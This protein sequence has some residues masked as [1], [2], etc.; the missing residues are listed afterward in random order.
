MRNRFRLAL[1]AGCAVLTLAVFGFALRYRP[2]PR[3]EYDPAYW[4]VAESRSGNWY[5][6]LTPAG[7]SYHLYLPPG[8][9]GV[10]SVSQVP[11][12]VAFHGSTGKATAK[13]RYGSLFAAGEAQ[14]AFVPR[15]AAVL[16][17]Q[18]RVEYFSDPHAYSRL[19]R[20]VALR[21]RGID[22]GRIAG[23]GFSKGAA[24]ATE[25]AMHDPAL[26]RVVASGS[27]Y[28]AASPAEL[29]RAAR[30]RFWCALSKDDQE[31]YEQGVAT[32]RILSLACPD[33]RYVEYEARGHFYIE[34][35]DS[36][37]RGDETFIDWLA[38]ALR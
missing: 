4:S 10:E 13:D 20:N 38:R 27:S 8:A 12:I 14:A 23:W 21:Y 26:F 31:I 11:L 6:G 9:D 19:I 30:V 25:L 18:S 24:F 3:L 7:F 17:P 2:A 15:G 16:V 28:Y 1:G 34:P 36:C 29:F 33:S 35:K 32:A 37:G 5:W 22:A